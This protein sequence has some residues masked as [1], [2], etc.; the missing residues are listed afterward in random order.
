MLPLGVSDAI[1]VP[2]EMR[3]QDRYASDSDLLGHA[4]HVRFTPDS[5]RTPDIELGSAQANR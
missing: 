3:V 4:G 1:F 2:G 5:D